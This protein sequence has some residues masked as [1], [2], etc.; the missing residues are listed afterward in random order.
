MAKKKTVKKTTKTAVHKHQWKQA[1]NAK[2]T[3]TCSR[4]GMKRNMKKV[5]AGG[6][7]GFA[8]EIT[9]TPV[10]GKAIKLERHHNFKT[11]ACKPSSVAKA[12]TEKKAK[13]AA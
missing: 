10:N 12:K 1:S 3:F 4:C 8:M 11:P 2:F 13:A 6:R 7:F 9:F 5:K